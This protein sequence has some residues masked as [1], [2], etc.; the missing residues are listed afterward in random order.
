MAKIL[1]GVDLRKVPRATSNESRYPWAEWLDGQARELRRSEDFDCSVKSLAGAAARAARDR[2]LKIVT[3]P[4]RADPDVV[5]V[6]AFPVPGPP[7]RRP[8]GS[9]P[10]ARLTAIIRAQIT[11]DKLAPG[12]RLPPRREV[13]ATYNVAKATVDRALDTLA[14]EG[15]VVAERGAGT[16]VRFPAGVPVK[17]EAAP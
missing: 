8:Y 17:Q 14:G 16:F 4:D 10:A 3:R 11:S 15:L 6:Q 7:P 13:A 12:T 9:I 2:N 5:R 1:P